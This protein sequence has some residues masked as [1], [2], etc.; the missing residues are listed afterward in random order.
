[1]TKSHSLPRL[2][3]IWC[4]PPFL[5]KIFLET[6]HSVGLFKKDVLSKL[7]KWVYNDSTH[8]I[9]SVNRGH[10]EDTTCNPEYSHNNH[11]RCWDFYFLGECNTHLRHRR[12]GITS[13]RV[14]HLALTV[15]IKLQLTQVH[16][17]NWVIFT[18]ESGTRSGRLSLRSDPGS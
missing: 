6:D 5:P 1:M 18:F 8:N 7:P 10:R 13:P 9:F 3:S 16:S 12:I 17:C 14:S 11:I 2:V 15:V 4:V